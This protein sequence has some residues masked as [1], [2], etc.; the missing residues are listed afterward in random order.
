M[1]TVLIQELIRY[2]GLLKEMKISLIQLNKALKGFIVMSD[3]LE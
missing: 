2:N 1:N 3:D